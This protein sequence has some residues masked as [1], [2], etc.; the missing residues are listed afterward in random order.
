VNL[1]YG[2]T[3]IDETQHATWIK[4]VSYIAEKDPSI[5]LLLSNGVMCY[6]IDLKQ[7]IFMGSIMITNC[8]YTFRVSNLCKVCTQNFVLHNFP[9]TYGPTDKEITIEDHL[10]KLIFYNDRYILKFWWAPK[11][12][13]YLYFWTTGTLRLTQPKYC[14]NVQ[15]T[16]PINSANVHYYHFVLYITLPPCKVTRL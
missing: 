3:A 6:I 13:C 14:N 9:V 5:T 16:T 7:E 1:A 4:S 15:V 11:D 2:I 10:V 8:F 12:H